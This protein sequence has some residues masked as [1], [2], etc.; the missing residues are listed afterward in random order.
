MAGML[1]IVAFVGYS[2]GW[3]VPTMTKSTLTDSSVI[4]SC[5]NEPAADAPAMTQDS[6]PLP[7]LRPARPMSRAALPALYGLAPILGLASV[8]WALRG[9]LAGIGEVRS[10]AWVGSSLT[11]SP[12]ADAHTRARVAAEGLLALGRSETMYYVA[13][14]DDRGRPLR[15]RCR[16]RVEGPAPAARWWSLTAYGADYYLFDAPQGRYSLNAQGLALDGAGRF[17]LATG[18]QATPG[19]PWLPTPGDQALVLTLRLY[20]PEAALQADPATLVPP[21]IHPIG[22]C[23]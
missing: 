2:A 23:R 8:L 6:P 20:N 10:G 15:S 4:G 14:Q 12:Q 19:L 5:L 22:D 16:Y 3:A 7:D 9:P 1:P 13:R 17:A 21:A 11:G 18:E